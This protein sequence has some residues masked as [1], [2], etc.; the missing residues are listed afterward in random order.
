MALPWV[1]ESTA[2]YLLHYLRYA[3]PIYLLVF[4]LLAFT[5]YSIKTARASDDPDDGDGAVEHGPGGK[6]LPKR[7]ASRDLRL[8]HD[9]EM[10]R[11]RRLLFI[12]ITA[13]TAATFLANASAVVLHTLFARQDGWWCGKEVVFYIVASFFVYCLHLISLIDQ[14]NS[15]TPV[16]LWTWI[17]ATV[18]E[19]VM[20]GAALAVYTH[21]HAEPRSDANLGEIRATTKCLIRDHMTDWEL[22]EVF[23]DI[24]RVFLL[25]F[26]VAFYMLFIVFRR[27]NFTEAKV[28]LAN[29]DEPTEASGL[30][31]EQRPMNGSPNAQTTG[32]GAAATGGRHRH[33]EGA[34]PGWERPTTTPSRSW[35]E[36]LR[37]YGMLFPYLW[38]SKDRRLQIIVVI[39]FFI[40]F[41]Q[42][43]VQIAVP[44]QTGVITNILS[45]RYP[46][47]P[48]TPII[49]YIVFRFLQG[50]NGLLGAL[51]GTLWIP[52]SQYSYR[53]L[54]VASFEHVHGL[55]L[56]FHLGKKTGEVLSALG[57]GSSINTFLEQVSFQVVPMLID[58]CVAIAY[59]LYAFDAYYALIVAIVTFWYV[60]ITIR[61]AQWRADIR[62][63][64]VNADREED[65]VK[66][67]SMVS[68]ETVKYFNAEPWEFN[69]YIEAVNKYQR[70]EYQVLF[71]LNL[72]NVCQ[73]MV[74]MMGLMVACF[75]AA[76]QVSTHQRKVGQFVTLITYMAQLQSPL[77]FFGTFYRMIQ[78]AMINAERMLELFKEKPTVVDSPYTKAL[79]SC[80]G[81][82]SF[83]DV[84]FAYD[85]RKPALNGL[86]FDCKPGTTTALVGESGGGKSTVFRLLFRFYDTEAGSIQVDGH[87]VH[88]V[89]IDSL[90]S[91]IGVVPQDTVL[92]NET[93]MYNL[94]YANQSATD[95]EVYDACRKASIHDKI[96]S[97]PEGYYTKVGERGLRLSGGEKQ[98]VAIARTIIKNPRIILLDEATAALDTETEEHIQD[99][100]TTLGK[101]RTML[102]IAHRLSTITLADQILVLH[103]GRVDERGTH[104]E[105]L[106]R[107]GRYDKMWKKQ[108]RAQK[109]AE[110]ARVLK[111]RAD[112]LK[113]EVGADADVSSAN[114]SEEESEEKRLEGMRP[115][116]GHSSGGSSGDLL[117]LGTTSSTKPPG[118]P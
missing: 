95:E 76:W 29:G 40:V 13:G 82:V 86:D 3:S 115:R 46:D 12:W 79:P 37:G 112:R 81:G 25:T 8:L 92:F 7:A 94:K 118:H 1:S 10:G 65:A 114:H 54:S 96:V 16:H 117:D 91:H 101:G 103:E 52:V 83:S 6:P 57:K 45:E 100:L 47:M 109:A 50:G 73:N 90:R 93:L 69:R 42:R 64:M 21:P 56:E 104:E 14:K 39:C 87:D 30:L 43:I 111:D 80:E 49:V 15:P 72:M 99:A 107:K 51:R 27:D 24:I 19:V 105:L 28:S 59:F 26:L 53:E 98:R 63:Q 38:P 60:Y 11:P 36:Y 48:W 9:Q 55:S 97:F 102:I 88:D 44:Y 106:A 61:M 34:A 116:Q 67:D 41:L 31:S 22:A 108:V 18:T 23:I 62:R 70:A 2:Q 110:Q 35:W 113:R 33:T 66:N 89:T 17:A 77:N 74:F 71:S 32:Y 75:V 68:Y 5:A 84:R 58:L 4:F 78:S 20:L 85:A